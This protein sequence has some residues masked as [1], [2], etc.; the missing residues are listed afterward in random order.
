MLAASRAHPGTTGSLS[1]RTIGERQKHLHREDETQ[2]R[3]AGGPDVVQHEISHRRTAVR[4]SPFGHWT[5]TLHLE[6]QIQ[7]EYP[8]EAVL[9]RP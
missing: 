3:F 1:G 8:V 2:D 6:G 7:G 9:Y 5:E 4:S